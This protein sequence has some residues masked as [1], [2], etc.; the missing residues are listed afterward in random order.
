MNKNLIITI[1]RQ[2]GSGGK[3]IG[4]KLAQQMNI[5][6]Y[7]KHTI[8]QKAKEMGI[9]QDLFEKAEERA[10]DSLIYSLAMGQYGMEH[11]NVPE[12]TLYDKIYSI[13]SSIIKQAAEQ[14][15][16]VIVGRSA[17]AILKELPYC[18]RLFVH[19]DIKK[20]LERAI[21][22]YHLSPEDSNEAY[23][24]RR[25]RRR[26]SY[27]QYYNDLEWEQAASYHLAMD[28]GETDLDCCVRIVLEYLKTYCD[29]REL[30]F[31]PSVAEYPGQKG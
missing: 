27:H 29:K 16:C 7:E 10:N 30:P 26:S 23:I 11:G 17:G 1:A 28:S 2:F 9:N 31:P 21:K 8:I 12:L 14:G 18:I 24:R 25:D 15:P 5:P 6:C 4:R 22:F 3:E 19:A 13:Q 20:R